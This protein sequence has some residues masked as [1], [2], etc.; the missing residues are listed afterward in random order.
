MVNFYHIL[1]TQGWYLGYLCGMA[2]YVRKRSLLDEQT[3]EKFISD[4]HVRVHSGSTWDRGRF[5]KLFLP[6]IDV[7]MRFKPSELQLAMHV[8]Q[9]LKS[10]SRVIALSFSSYQDFCQVQLGKT[11]DRS[12]YHK[13]VKAL[14]R[15]GLLVR[16]GNEW[17]VNH[18]LV[19]VGDRGKY[20]FGEKLGESE[21]GRG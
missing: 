14:V 6:A 11:A 9:R 2:K 13:A 3:G 19:F 1:G 20:L 17:L 12:A 16:S 18:H 8:L 4:E 15:E 5:V 7:L 10:G 21:L